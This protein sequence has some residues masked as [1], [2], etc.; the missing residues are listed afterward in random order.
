MRTQF[1]SVFKIK[2][3]FHKEGLL[4][5]RP[6]SKMFFNRLILWGRPIK[7][8][9]SLQKLPTHKSF[10]RKTKLL[11]F[12]FRMSIPKKT[13]FSSS[14]RKKSLK[15]FFGRKAYFPSVIKKRSLQSETCFAQKSSVSFRKIFFNRPF[16]KGR[17]KVLIAWAVS[18]F[19]EKKT[20]ELV[21]KLKSIGFAY[22][23]K[24]G[25][26]LSIDDLKIPPSK[27]H[28]ICTAEQ[29]L[30]FTN[31]EVKKGHLTSIEYFSKVIE[32]WNKT[33]ES[34]KNEVIE[35]FKTTDELNPVFLMA[36]SGAR[37]NMSQVR[38]LTSM[39]GLMSD[40]QGRII[41]FP[42]QS[43]FREGLT[44]T[45]YVISCYGARKGVVDT[46]L[47]TATSGYLTRRLVDVAQHVIIGSFDCGTTRGIWLKDLKKG[48][49][50][51]LP[52]K[53]RIVG[54]RL[55]EDIYNSQNLLIATKN[56]EI[57]TRLA[58][59][60][61][62]L[63]TSVF[64]RSSLT[65]KDKNYV[66]QLCYGWSLANHRLVPSGE[67][68]GIISAQSIGEPGTQL[69]MRTF[70]TG[71]VFSGEISEELKSP[72]RGIVSFSK[73]IPGKLIR[74][75]Y[76]QIAFLT[77]Q[78][79]S[80]FVTPKNNLNEDQIREV[81]AKIKISLQESQKKVNQSFDL[82]TQKFSLNLPAYTL[83][84]V[85]QNQFVE[86]QQI[87]GES[88]TFLTEQNQS[89]E[90][91]QT[92][93]SELS[94]EVRFQ[95][96]KQIQ[97]EK[98]QLESL[99]TDKEAPFSLKAEARR[100]RNIFNSTITSS[101]GEFWVLSSQEQTV[102]NPINFLVKPGDFI[103][104]N[105]RF[106]LANALKLESKETQSKGNLLGKICQ[107]N[108]W[109]SNR[110]ALLGT[111]H[112]SSLKVKSK[113]KFVNSTSS[114]FFYDFGQFCVFN[115]SKKLFDP[116]QN[117]FF[118]LTL[119]NPF[120]LKFRHAT[121]FLLK[122]NTN[123]PFKFFSE[124][125]TFEWKKLFSQVRKATS[126]E[127]A[128]KN[129]SHK[130]E[131]LFRRQSFL[132]LFLTLPFR[133]KGDEKQLWQN[134]NQ[135]F[136]R[137]QLRN[138][139]FLDS[140]VVF[141]EGR[142]VD[143]FQ[144]NLLGQSKIPTKRLFSTSSPSF[145]RLQLEVNSNK[146]G[147]SQVKSPNVSSN[148]MKLAKNTQIGFLPRFK[149]LTGGFGFHERFY[150]TF[151]SRLKMSSFFLL[152]QF[153]KNKSLNNIENYTLQKV[154]FRN[155]NYQYFEPSKKILGSQKGFPNLKFSTILQKQSNLNQLR[156]NHL[157]KLYLKLN[158]VVLFSGEHQKSFFNNSMLRSDVI[159]VVIDSNFRKKI[160]KKGTKIKPLKG[161]IL[162]TKKGQKAPSNSREKSLSKIFCLP[163]GISFPKTG[164]PKN[165]S[166]KFEN[167]LRREKLPLKK[168]L[169]P[170]IDEV[171]F[172]TCEKSLFKINSI[173][174]K[175][176]TFTRLFF[177]GSCVV[178][179]KKIM[180]PF[181]VNPTPKKLTFHMSLSQPKTREEDVLKT[182][183][184]K[185]LF[186][187]VRKATS[188][189]NQQNLIDAHTLSPEL[190]SI[191]VIG[192]F[193][194]NNGRIKQEFYLK[195]PRLKKEQ[196]RSQIFWFGHQQK[197]KT[198]TS[199]KK[200]TNKFSTEFSIKKGPPLLNP[201]SWRMEQQIAFQIF[202]TVFQFGDNSVSSF[203]FLKMLK[204]SQFSEQG[205]PFNLQ[206]FTKEALRFKERNSFLKISSISNLPF[207]ISS[208]TADRF[209]P[210]FDKRLLFKR[211]DVIFIKKSQLRRSIIYYQLFQKYKKN[212]FFSRYSKIKPNLLNDLFFLNALLKSAQFLNIGL[213]KNN[214]VFTKFSLSK[215]MN[216]STSSVIYEPSLGSFSNRFAPIEKNALRSRK[217]P[218]RKRLIQFSNSVI[219]KQKTQGSI[220][221]IRKSKSFTQTLFA[222]VF[223]ISWNPFQTFSSNVNFNRSPFL[224]IQDQVNQ[225]KTISSESILDLSF[226]FLENQSYYQSL[227]CCP[228][229]RSVLNKIFQNL[230]KQLS[231]DNLV[232][233]VSSED[234]NIIRSSEKNSEGN[235]LTVKLDELPLNL[236]NKVSEGGFFD[237]EPLSSFS[238]KYNI[239]DLKL[240]EKF[241]T[242]SQF[243]SSFILL[244]L[245]LASD[246]SLSDEV[247]FRTCEKSFFQ[248]D[249]FFLLFEMKSV[250]TTNFC[251]TR[252]FNF[253]LTRR[254]L[255]FSSQKK[256]FHSQNTEQYPFFSNF[257]QVNKKK[258]LL[259]Q[260]ST[261][262]NK[263]VNLQNLFFKQ[264]NWGQLDNQQLTDFYWFKKKS[265]K[266]ASKNFLLIT[267]PGWVCTLVNPTLYLHKHNCFQSHGNF[268][269][270]DLSFGNYRTL[271]K[272]IPLY[273]RSRSIELQSNFDW[274]DKILKT[275]PVRLSKTVSF[276]QEG[277]L[278]E[279]FL[280]KVSDG[281]G[282]Q[283]NLLEL[284]FN[285]VSSSIPSRIF[286]PNYLS[287]IETYNPTKQELEDFQILVTNFS[288]TCFD[289]VAFQTPEKRFNPGSF[290]LVEESSW[291]LNY[292]SRKSRSRSLYQK[293]SLKDRSSK[294]KKGKNLF[295]V[296]PSIL[297]KM[298][299]GNVLRIFSFN[300][301]KFSELNQKT[302]LQLLD[303]CWF[304]K[305]S[306][307]KT[308]LFKQ[309]FI[310]KL[311][312]LFYFSRL[313][314]F[315]GQIGLNSSTIQ[316][317]KLL[318]RP[319]S[320]SVD[321]KKSF[322]LNAESRTNNRGNFSLRFKGTKSDGITAFFETTFNNLNKNNKGT[323]RILVKKQNQQL[324]NNYCRL[325]YFKV[326]NLPGFTNKL[327]SIDS[328]AR[329]SYRFVLATDQFQNNQRSFGENNL[330]DY[331]ALKKKTNQ[332][333]CFSMEI[334]KS[335][336]VAS[337]VK[338]APLLN[339]HPFH[340]NKNL[341]FK[342]KLLIL[343]QS[344]LKQSVFSEKL[345]QLRRPYSYEVLSSCGTSLLTKEPFL[346]FFE[347]IDEN[348]NFQ[349]IKIQETLSQKLGSIFQNPIF[350]FSKIG[351]TNSKI[352]LKFE[353]RQRFN[354]I[355]NSAQ[356][357]FLTQK[358]TQYLS[359]NPKNV[360]KNTLSVIE[361]TNF[362]KT[363]RTS[364]KSDFVAKTTKSISK[365][366]FFLNLVFIKEVLP[367]LKKNTI[368][369]VKPFLLEKAFY[370]KENSI[371]NKII[372]SKTTRVSH[373]ETLRV[374]DFQKRGFN[375][376]KLVTL[377]K[378]TFLTSSKSDDLGK[379]FFP[380]FLKEK[381]RTTFNFKDKQ[382][383]SHKFEKLLRRQAIFSSRKLFSQVQKA[384][385]SEKTSQ[386]SSLN[387][388]IISNF[389]KFKIQRSLQIQW[390]FF[391]LASSKVKHSFP[392][393]LENISFGKVNSFQNRGD[394]LFKIQKKNGQKKPFFTSSKS[395]FVAQRKS[396]P[397][398]FP[399]S[400]NFVSFQ[401]QKRV[402]ERL[403][404]KNTGF[405]RFSG[406]VFFQLPQFVKPH[407][408][409]I[410][411]K[412]GYTSRFFERIDFNSYVNAKIH[413]KIASLFNFVYFKP[414]VLANQSSQNSLFLAADFK[415]S[416]FRAFFKRL[417]VISFIQTT[418]SLEK[419]ISFLSFSPAKIKDIEKTSFEKEKT[420]QA[421]FPN[422][423]HYPSKDLDFFKHNR[424]L[425]LFQFHFST[426]GSF[427]P[428]YSLFF[429]NRALIKKSLFQN[430]FKLTS[431][432]LLV[433]LKSLALA[434]QTFPRSRKAFA[435][436]NTKS[437]D[438][439]KLEL[440][441]LLKGEVFL[442]RNT[443]SFKLKDLV[444]AKKNQPQLQLL[445]DL[446][447]KTF[448]IK[449]SKHDNNRFQSKPNAFLSK[450]SSQVRK[451]TSSE[452][453]SLKV[454]LGE[455]IRYG[456]E[457]SPGV[458]VHQSGQIVILQQN[459]VVLRYAKPFLLSAGGFCDLAQGDFVRR[460]S[461][462]LT[463]KYKTLKTEDIVQ[464]IPKIEQ[465]F[466][467]RDNFEEGVG[468]NTLLLNKFKIENQ[469]YPKHIAVRKSVE[470]IQHYIIDGIQY[471][472]QSQ[473]VNISDKH[474]EI[475]VKQ[476][477]SKVQIIDPSISG[478]LRGDIVYLDWIESVNKKLSGKKVHYEPMVLGIT[479]A[480]LDIRGFVSAA[481][482][483]E[484]IKILTNA[485]LLQRSD[486][487]RGLKENVILG[488]LIRAGTGSN[489]TT[490][491]FKKKDE[492]KKVLID[493]AL[494]FAPINSKKGKKKR[495]N[496]KTKKPNL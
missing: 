131:K 208:V 110:K 183:L 200:K 279:S 170:I 306:N 290:L 12:K 237:F 86:E 184:F 307:K 29:I 399:V 291:F 188:S 428:N 193:Q 473:G 305:L 484:T 317:L 344:P 173:K 373:L 164:P 333:I 153:N 168:N 260:L 480:A 50:V 446:D 256:L 379:A 51:L 77:K 157:L 294:L 171:A 298:R 27:K 286:L 495:L 244:L 22:G 48:L 338:R 461:P 441:C 431:K 155:L 245:K 23:T 393:K 144:S 394:F 239:D 113:T 90:S 242:K 437:S 125:K 454:S 160:I 85:K 80:L 226:I 182:K 252:G 493:P 311:F 483:Q 282:N 20:V 176:K 340:F 331:V 240:I 346:K 143:S 36:F 15:S 485:T 492:K 25:I 5:K 342:P 456:K 247:A 376:E 470:F 49:K 178:C 156:K 204:T 67:A 265:E 443:L 334:R 187:Q 463:L 272:F 381:L 275:F 16:D 357:L 436:Q 466:E 372:F 42:I 219:L 435:G 70:H 419:K 417:K 152:A 392:A 349:K 8:T 494:I 426:K 97:I 214:L 469:L 413:S 442:A 398:Y 238:F 145:K 269:V 414:Y 112:F 490:R 460:Q 383:F 147:K 482:F 434:S 98:N 283:F 287:F 301:A 95:K 299:L 108:T 41:N 233:P 386:T 92:L 365:F 491:F 427:H 459:K 479:K 126:L 325:V 221:Q 268:G 264:K 309:V 21:E 467:A 347:I 189:K 420:V 302:H 323:N 195:T 489:L 169:S 53:K 329:S 377:Q 24:A 300:R 37:G 236:E 133:V 284:N 474:I 105:A 58:N 457:I 190:T 440:K 363:F 452:K 161:H 138:K 4:Q 116:N 121:L 137:G 100:M 129:F 230:K 71:G 13:Y 78:K 364:S 408:T 250:F 114:I 181:L 263:N 135:P 63:K 33:S 361:R 146:A 285:D 34:L 429:Y 127:K 101:I 425:N 220:F 370:S 142:K 83:L 45:E 401:N 313:D 324:I 132:E 40:P 241:L 192:L 328:M 458:G 60:I 375:F 423:I 94:G 339:N 387:K 32:T 304:D 30:D 120:K 248:S 88:S 140:N 199:F 246:K 407:L 79:S 151:E 421:I 465:L 496:S 397:F 409:T 358:A 62:K 198:V 159:F 224:S 354:F 99:I 327:A 222:A 321:A 118:N 274:W 44:L 185:K 455:F 194:K 148:S 180:N 9:C 303:H 335:G 197:I 228:F 216:P 201:D 35:N 257:L 406:T 61:T 444:L 314:L 341:R 56:Q 89:V 368:S 202:K 243:H 488:H 255:N 232:Y 289:E 278:E 353:D 253:L 38:Q 345:T 39:R 369:K 366:P 464:G 119:V 165:F 26:S 396:K 6:S 388:Q 297:C 374:S 19:G 380:L 319:Q 411:F 259:K 486:Y 91:Y 47:K 402:Q 54:R 351:S 315:S 475:I 360:K 191:N 74:T 28:S 273:L 312:L 130:F 234:K 449:K 59:Q 17:L 487:L 254:K 438:L 453:T 308:A 362:K 235:L 111:S 277:L 249:L 371:R 276:Y 293:G 96:T 447:F 415:L 11:A 196:S 76:G 82:T 136:I 213:D 212:E 416:D 149:T 270:N 103:H 478:L 422:E 433:N 352:E 206:A 390:T 162:E 10:V 154:T 384:T 207:L 405:K 158:L 262:K 109:N 450:L 65:C 267:Y 310:L 332:N 343:G 73:S 87:L 288:Q 66:C 348:R 81:N 3:I 217:A 52:L 115:S 139:F 476:M 326:S 445:T 122:A 2:M 227:I 462:L 223:N 150:T 261:K 163:Q 385:S 472:Y 410:N 55:A 430:N 412:Q 316:K 75:T 64:V 211:N 471:V 172:R 229:K 295:I 117:P 141:A 134:L 481:S 68:I 382:N 175:T 359:K 57:G 93:Y 448:Q 231:M 336:H 322:L 251:L 356:T 179:F 209:K 104:Q 350:N 281:L 124:Q 186:S 395:Y 266:T 174:G 84:F 355:I 439:T 258:I 337:T 166:H 477:T 403:N 123:Q 292:L 106:Y 404:P 280:D 378:K 31:Q 18:Y 107:N 203:Y 468:V 69:T 102:L 330:R 225:P 7:N 210:L 451:A 367:L 46:A 418:F 424:P 43:N 128:E 391:N 320:Q 215:V 318:I 167:L 14:S 389:L 400:Q 177:N 1:Y 218:A 296:H 72:I 432:Q 271:T 205:K